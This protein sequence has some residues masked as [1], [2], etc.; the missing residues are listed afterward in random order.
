MNWPD[1]L[2]L[3]P[4]QKRLLHDEGIQHV[5]ESLRE[6]N[7]DTLRDLFST[8]SS[9][10]L[11]V[12]RL[13]KNLL[14]QSYEQIV[15]K[16]RPTT[17]GNIRSLWYSD[18]KPVLSRADVL[19]DT[20]AG[21]GLMSE[22]LA[23]LVTQKLLRY[24][25]FDFTDEHYDDRK[26]GKQTG[27]VILA[28][29]KRGQ[30]RWLKRMHQ[31]HGVTVIA[32]GGQ[33]SLLSTEYFVDELKRAKVD[34]KKSMR[35][36]TVMDYDPAG[37]S[38]AQSFVRQLKGFGVKVSKRIDLVR[39]EYMTKEQIALGRYRLSQ[40]RRD[41]TQVKR[42]VELTGG[43]DGKPHGIEADAMTTAQLSELFKNLRRRNS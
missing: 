19:R 38:I 35:L 43:V 31:A 26:I 34:I 11:N 25:D 42:W 40:K 21:Y 39:P 27:R 3:T 2:K 6:M 4:K 20:D 12:T 28:A 9:E 1:K 22:L 41:H 14:W 17:D 10:R 32:L 24:Q 36:I 37:E 8:Q 33:P 18:V 23:N 13:V 29:E 7:A 15:L 30:W 16:Q 5:E